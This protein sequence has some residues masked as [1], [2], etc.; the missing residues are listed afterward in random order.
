MSNYTVNSTDP[1][2]YNQIQINLSNPTNWQHAIFTVSSL[3]T[4]ANII[5]INEDDFIEFNVYSRDE[6]K[7]FRYNVK[8]EYVNFSFLDEVFDILTATLQSCDFLKLNR[9]ATNIIYFVAQDSV[10]SF[11]MNMAYNLILLTGFYS[12]T[13]QPVQCN[14]SQTYGEI[15]AKTI[16]FLN[17]THI[18][19]LFSTL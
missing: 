5:L 8:G 4:Q 17:N 14:N 16:D 2:H 18:F 11:S 15:T 19:Y 1:N 10:F 6:I 7:T 3:V 12:E 13:T 9:T